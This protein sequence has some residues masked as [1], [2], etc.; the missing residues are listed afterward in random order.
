MSAPQDLKDQIAAAFRAVDSALPPLLLAQTAALSATLRL[1][2]AQLA[3]AWEAHALT[4]G[5]AELTEGTFG[6]Y[7]T[8]LTK[9]AG[10]GGARNATVIGTTGLGKRTAPGS[11]VTPSPAAKRATAGDAAPGAAPGLAPGL[12]PGATPAAAAQT[13]P[14]SGLSAVDGLTTPSGRGPGSP[15]SQ[16]KPGSAATV[17]TPVKSRAAPKFADRPQPG[18]VVATYNPA[19]LPP[20]AARD[21]AARGRGP[22]AVALH[23]AAARRWAD[24]EGP[25]RH[26]FAPLEERSAALEERLTGM[27]E[28]L[29]RAH[30]LRTEEEEQEEEM[31]QHVEGG[32]GAGA[33]KG[34]GRGAWAPVCP[35]GVPMQSKVVCIGRVCN[36]VRCST[37]GWASKPFVIGSPTQAESSNCV[38]GMMAIKPLRS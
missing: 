2:P 7:R 36:E 1:K 28:A 22:A 9:L 33:E 27:G 16:A 15:S 10:D 23:P 14:R 38:R 34:T 30:G 13:R 31:L 17:I 25:F 18:A 4:K 29:H 11:H 19:G 20:A 24:A 21:R 37:G 12:T 32:G 6:A 3:E 26:M 5:V 8:A 35:V